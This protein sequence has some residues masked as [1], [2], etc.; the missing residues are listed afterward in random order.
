[1]LALSFARSVAPMAFALR[2]SVLPLID[3]IMQLAF[4]KGTE[5]C[6]ATDGLIPEHECEIERSAINLQRFSRTKY[7]ETELQRHT[8]LKRK[9]LHS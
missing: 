8:K 9:N 1:V 2:F 6:V 5:P 7:F 3:T 4:D